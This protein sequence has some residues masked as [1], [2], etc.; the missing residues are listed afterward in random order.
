MNYPPG[1]YPPPPGHYPPPPHGYYGYGPQ[2]RT[3]GFA[4]AALVLGI[5]WFYWITSILAVIFGHLAVSQCNRS[6]GTVTGKGMAIAG[7]VLGYV[8]LALLVL[9][10]AAVATGAHIG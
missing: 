1:Q 4:I 8:W 9:L 5:V 6:G 3:N 10:I 7:L 2:T